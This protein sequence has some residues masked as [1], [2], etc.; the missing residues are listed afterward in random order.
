MTVCRRC[1]LPRPLDEFVARAKT[2]LSGVCEGCR[3]P[4]DTRADQAEREAGWLE[5]SALLAAVTGEH[6]RP[7]QTLLDADLIQTLLDSHSAWRCAGRAPA[8]WPATATRV[9]DRARLQV[10]GSAPAPLAWRAPPAAALA[11]CTHRCTG[12]TEHELH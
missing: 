8:Q 6:W 1:K 12:V 9:V 7:M 3:S 4:E 5:G 10:Q 2:A 11:A